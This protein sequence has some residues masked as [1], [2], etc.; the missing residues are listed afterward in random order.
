LRSPHGQAGSVTVVA[1]GIMAVIVVSTIG[2]ADVGKALIAR[3]HAQQAADAAALAAAQELA[4][5]SGRAPAEWAGEF[6]RR[7]GAALAS[8]ACP[9]GS[10]DALVRVTVPVGRLLLLPGDHA[11]A[12]SARA[13]VE[14]AQSPAGSNSSTGFPA[15]SS[16]RT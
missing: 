2:V 1:A 8:C 14:A 7:N 11:V 16:I 6:A 12:A 13:I 9:D 4:V 3:Q 5:P 10:T 15:G